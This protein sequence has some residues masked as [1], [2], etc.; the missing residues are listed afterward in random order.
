M[1]IKKYYSWYLCHKFGDKNQDAGAGVYG[2]GLIQLSYPNNQDISRFRQAVA[3]GSLEKEW[4]S[5][6]NKHWK[7]I[8]EFI[9]KENGLNLDEVTVDTDYGKKG[10]KELFESFPVKD[11]NLAFRRRLAIHGT[12]DPAG[13]GNNISGGCIRMHNEHIMELIEKY[14]KIGIHVVLHS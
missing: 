5:F 3:D 14:V 13:I 6:C 7:P 1:L 11:F 12:N 8:F 4:G 10:F 2:T 9:A